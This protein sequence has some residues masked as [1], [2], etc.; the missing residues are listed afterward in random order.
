MRG[1]FE[2]KRRVKEGGWEKDKE[3]EGSEDKDFEK[4]DYVLDDE[5]ATQDGFWFI[6]RKENIAEKEKPKEGEE[7]KSGVFGDEGETSENPSSQ[8]KARFILEKEAEI[9]EY[10]EKAKEPKKAVGIDHLGDA[11]ENGI[12]AD[13]EQGEE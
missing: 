1:T 3:R 7:K 6:D 13:K 12:C 8:E 4:S 2:E 11:D 9:T 10:G 5:L